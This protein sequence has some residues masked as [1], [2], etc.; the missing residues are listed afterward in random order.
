LKKELPFEMNVLLKGYLYHAYPLGVLFAEDDEYLPVILNNFVQLRAD[1]KREP[2]FDFDEPLYPNWPFLDISKIDSSIASALQL[3]I[4]ESIIRFID[5]GY[6]VDT[7]IDEFYV[8]LKTNYNKRHITHVVLIYGYDLEA[9][10]LLAVSYLH[11]HLYE[12]F[13]IAFEDFQQAVSGDRFRRLHI[14]KKRTSPYIDQSINPGLIASKIDQYLHSATVTNIGTH[15]FY[16]E[17]ELHVGLQAC[18]QLIN[19]LDA[20]IAAPSGADADVDIRAFCILWEHKNC[21][22]LRFQAM[23]TAYPSPSIKEACE[24]YEEIKASCKT[25]IN[26]ILKFYKTRDVKLLER[27]KNAVQSVIAKEE[28]VLGAFLHEFHRKKEPV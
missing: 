21:M 10:Q 5:Q 6:Y 22:L 17:D 24:T 25:I 19:H 27:C 16:E 8:P 12:R 26:Q 28:E 2:W 13:T 14:F 9:R 11:N 3:D 15:Q 1:P 20:F 7:C 18:R 23:L 4:T